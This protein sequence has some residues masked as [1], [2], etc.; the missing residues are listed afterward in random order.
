[1]LDL[2]EVGVEGFGGGRALGGRRGG[3]HRTE[4]RAPH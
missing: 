4:Y 2:E 3:L 1:L